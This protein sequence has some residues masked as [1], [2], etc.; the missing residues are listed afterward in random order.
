M[1]TEED[2][3]SQNARISIGARL[4]VDLPPADWY[5]M[6]AKAV[7]GAEV[8]PKGFAIPAY[9]CAK[10]TNLVRSLLVGIRAEGGT[11]TFVY[12]TGT[13]DLNIVAPVWG[14]PTLVYGPGD[15]AMDHTPNENISINEYKKAVRVLTTALKNLVAKSENG[16]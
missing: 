11:P 6:L 5:A 7:P 1:V 2:G 12:K 14:C 13:A 8:E 9:E 3:F 15:S 4:P 16:L 10:N